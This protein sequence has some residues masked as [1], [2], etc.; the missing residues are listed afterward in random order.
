MVDNAGTISQA[1][2]RIKETGE[3]ADDRLVQIF[4][5]EMDLSLL[6]GHDFMAFGVINADDRFNTAVL[7]TSDP[8]GSL[9]R[10]FNAGLTYATLLDDEET[11]ITRGV[12]EPADCDALRDLWDLH[13]GDLGCGGDGIDNGD[14]DDDGETPDDNG[15][16]PDDNGDDDDDGETSGR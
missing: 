8:V 15:E 11:T 4:P 7:G 14:D 3:I 16:T 6:P 13:F 2:I 9:V 1:Y 10:G 5:A 12:I